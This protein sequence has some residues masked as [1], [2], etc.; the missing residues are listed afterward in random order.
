VLDASRGKQALGWTAATP[1]DAGLERTV[2][3]VRKEVPA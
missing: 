2:D 3:Y 1:F